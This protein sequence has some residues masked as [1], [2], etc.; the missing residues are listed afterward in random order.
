MGITPVETTASPYKYKKGKKKDWGKGK[1]GRRFIRLPVYLELCWIQDYQYLE[2]KISDR[3]G[4]ELL[5]FLTREKGSVILQMILNIDS[6]FH[7]CQLKR[8]LNF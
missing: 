2:I 4:K 6:P 8:T 5:F 3:F 1:D 7:I